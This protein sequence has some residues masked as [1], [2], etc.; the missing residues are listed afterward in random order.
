MDFH[1]TDIVFVA[2]ITKVFLSLSERNRLRRSAI[3]HILNLHRCVRDADDFVA[4]I[5]NLALSSHEYVIAV[6]QKYLFR[7]PT[8]RPAGP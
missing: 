5:H 7:L 2:A 8:A 1:Q 4:A 3:H 6:L